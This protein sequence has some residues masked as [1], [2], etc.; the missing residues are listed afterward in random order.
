MA[1]SEELSHAGNGGAGWGGAASGL[2]GE[3]ALAPAVQAAGEGP[4]PGDPP[5]P[6]QE[7]HTGAAGL[8]GSRAVEDDIPV[9]GDLPV[10]PF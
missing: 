10:A 5:A 7:R 3:A 9:A 8:V 6:Q 1:S 2:Q 4:N